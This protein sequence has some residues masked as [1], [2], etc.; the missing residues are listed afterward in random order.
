MFENVVLHKKV[1]GDYQ[2]NENTIHVAFGITSN[3]TR[4]V[5][6]LIDSIVKNASTCDFA[7]HIFAD[8]ILPNTEISR[9]NELTKEFPI[10]ITIY[11]FNNSDFH[12]LDTREFTIA[13]YYRFAIPMQL[14]YIPSSKYFAYIDADILCVGDFCKFK[15]INIKHYIAGV[16]REFKVDKKGNVQPY[17]EDDFYFNAGVMYINRDLWI[18]EM[19]SEKC[20]NILR[21]VNLNPEIKVSKYGYEFRCFDQDALNIVLKDRVLF[22]DIQY[23]FLTNI[24]QKNFKN[25]KNVPSDTIL[26][27]YHGYNKPW[28]QW[29][30]H[31]LANIYHKSMK[32][33]PWKDVPLDKNPSKYRQMRI[34]SKYF[35]KKWNIFKGIYWLLKSFQGKINHN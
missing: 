26:I 14:R 22:M 15:E 2:Y 12:G 18:K 4:P 32:N 11:H 13:T 30:F 35:F 5:G 7:F 20:L 21:E 28:H 9:F 29:C 1:L 27:H 33:S 34:Y 3:F 19:I 17:K 6:I 10:S 24:S 23:N 8:D 31:P 16:V 25:M